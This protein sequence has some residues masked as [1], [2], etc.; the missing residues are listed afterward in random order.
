MKKADGQMWWIII[1]AVLALLFFVMYSFGAF[2]IINEIFAG[3][4]CN[5]KNV[6]GDK[7]GV[8]DYFD[9]CPCQ[10][11]EISDNGCPADYV[12]ANGNIKKDKEDAV[13]KTCLCCNKDSDCGAGRTCD[14]E[15]HT[16]NK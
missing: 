2:P 5:I 14:K 13:I 16:C 1:F 9:K 7:D 4:K 15:T 12:D 3:T 11:G 10:S 6:D 8:V